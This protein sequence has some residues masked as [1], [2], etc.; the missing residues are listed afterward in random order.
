M[1][2]SKD[3][4]YELGEI[5]REVVNTGKGG[6]FLI[7]HAPTKAEIIAVYLGMEPHFVG[8]NLLVKDETT[9]K[10]VEPENKESV[11]QLGMISVAILGQVLRPQ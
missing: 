10:K 2:A 7:D 1:T 11:G 8:F 6:E 9:E 5:V 4:I 3:K